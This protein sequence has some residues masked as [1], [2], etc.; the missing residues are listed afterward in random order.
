M[1]IFTRIG[2]AALAWR[3]FAQALLAARG[4]NAQDAKAA[5]VAKIIVL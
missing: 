1:M 4:Q 3:R 5:A 2:V